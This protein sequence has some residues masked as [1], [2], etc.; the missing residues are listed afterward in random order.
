MRYKS[1]PYEVTI[2]ASSEE[3]ERVH[4]Q[5][6]RDRICAPST[7]LV[8]HPA[9]PDLEHRGPRHFG[10]RTGT[11]HKGLALGTVVVG[12]EVVGGSVAEHRRL[13]RLPIPPD[14]AGKS[15]DRKRTP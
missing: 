8:R 2:R 14:S 1:Q 11:A 6:H 4:L 7:R 3:E 13:V 12:T 15:K 9:W 5:A 10:T